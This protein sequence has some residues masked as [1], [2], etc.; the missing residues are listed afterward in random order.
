MEP[1]TFEIICRL[2]VKESEKSSIT[3][4]RETVSELVRCKDCKWHTAYSECTHR[5]WDID[6][7]NYP[8]VDEDDYCSYGERSE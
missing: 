7:N 3:Y 5:N 8:K 1:R 2:E 6:Q 4:Q